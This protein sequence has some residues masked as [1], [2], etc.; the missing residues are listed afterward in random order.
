MGPRQ[1]TNFDTILAHCWL[2][3]FV[4]RPVVITPAP[5]GIIGVEI[6]GDWCDLHV[7][8]LPSR[9]NAVHKMGKVKGKHLNF[10]R[11]GRDGVG[12]NRN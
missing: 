1:N 2:L 3:G 12:E 7:G 6:L 10:S 4:N 8:S 11:S 5:Q 9:V